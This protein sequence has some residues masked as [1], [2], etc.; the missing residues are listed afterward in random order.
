MDGLIKEFC[1]DCG[2]SYKDDY[3]GLHTSDKMCVGI[4]CNNPLVALLDLC[5][6][7][8]DYSDNYSDINLSDLL[9]KPC[10]ESIDNNSILYFPLV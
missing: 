9:G 1:E 4:V 10:I 8:I 7:I 2:Y 6:Y 5:Q 3:N